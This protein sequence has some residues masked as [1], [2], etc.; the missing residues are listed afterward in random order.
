METGCIIDYIDIRN[1]PFVLYKPPCNFLKIISK[2]AFDI[3][4]LLHLILLMSQIKQT[5]CLHK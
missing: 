3:T 1:T 5:H 2:N 4:F